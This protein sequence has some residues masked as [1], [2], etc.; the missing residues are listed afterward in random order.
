MGY[1]NKYNLM[2]PKIFPNDSN[3]TFKENPKKGAQEVKRVTK[4]NEEIIAA[5]AAEMKD[6][7]GS[8]VE[9]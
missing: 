4:S 8:K 5:V 2:D 3:Y 1:E 9:S 7:L 6:S